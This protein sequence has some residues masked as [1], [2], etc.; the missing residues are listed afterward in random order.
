M[1]TMGNLPSAAPEAVVSIDAAS[2]R[3]VN[4]LF[5][6]LKA[7]FP[8]WKQAWPT[9]EDET[10]AKKSWVK[11]FVAARIS[12]I[13][14]IR[15]GIEN[16]RKL[17]SS[18]IP[19]VGEFVA[20]CQPTPEMLGIPDHDQAYAEAIANAHPSM[21]GSREWSHQAV[22]HAASHCGFRGL[23]TMSAEASRKMFD[24]AY[25]ITIRMLLAGEPLRRIPL[26]LPR[27][28]ARR[29]SEKIGNEA[30]ALLRKNL[31]ARGHG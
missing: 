31:G 1:S 21:A 16:C 9:A 26:G 22:Y 13:E 23:S 15:F 24:R 4:A 27:P 19:S 8:A 10:S 6:E 14:Q 30:L 17:G 18:F 11:A 25:G 7:I 3:V 29:G 20:M 12:Q 5:R 28:V 2:A